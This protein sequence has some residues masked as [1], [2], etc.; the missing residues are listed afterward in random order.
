MIDDKA[1]LEGQRAA[2]REHIDKYKRYSEQHE[3]AFALR[4]IRNCQK[5]IAKIKSKHPHWPSSWEDNWT[6]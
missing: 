3:K 1:K 5:Q 2:I 4:T 6:P